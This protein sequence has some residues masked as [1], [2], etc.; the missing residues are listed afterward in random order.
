ML[1]RISWNKVGWARSEKVEEGCCLILEIICSTC[2]H[3]LSDMLNLLG[4][5]IPFGDVVLMPAQ[6]RWQLVTVLVGMR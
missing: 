1:L 4:I 3:N 5:V 2:F 6:E